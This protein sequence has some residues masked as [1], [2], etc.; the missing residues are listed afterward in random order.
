ME[1]VCCNLC[2]SNNLH[3]VYSKPDVLFH[4]N[5]TFSVVECQECGL[6]FVNPRPSV[7]E[8]ARYYPS[9]FYE[10]FNV[11]VD[12]H[13]MRY[14]VEAGFINSV[15]PNGIGRKLLDVGCA[16]GDFPRHMLKHGWSVEGVEVSA[17]SAHIKDFKVYNQA[18]NEIQV[19]DATYD[20]V[21]AWAVFEHVHDPMA[22]FAKAARVLRDDGYFVFLVTN[23]NS[24][25]SRYLYRE[26]IPRHLYFFTEKTVKRYLELNGMV[27]LK[28]D[29][30]NRIYSMTPIN[31]LRHYLR[32]MFGRPELKWT[33]TPLTRREYLTRH[34]L[35]NDIASNILYVLRNPLTVVD[36]VLVG[37]IERYQIMTKQYG[38]VTYVARKKSA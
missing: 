7:H 32:Q 28:S 24:I 17:N 33:D 34:G 18:F 22:Y 5:E 31:W 29:Y 9:S 2:G 21:T 6:G 10:Y 25:A 8:M 30:S 20:V 38:I 11:D 36:R 4:P 27:L 12:F 14:S 1:T 23:F 26:D 37:I 13:A 15:I 19:N 3:L 16:N 35:K